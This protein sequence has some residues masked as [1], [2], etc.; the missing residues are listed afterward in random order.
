MNRIGRGLRPSFALLALLAALAGCSSPSRADD[1]TTTTT[2][3]AVPTTTVAPLVVAGTTETGALGFLGSVKRLSVTAL[4]PGKA[5]SPPSA[6]GSPASG[7]LAVLGYRQFGAG[8][9]LLLLPAEGA[10]M[11]WWSPAFLQAL[12]A[13]YR[14]TVLD[15]PGVGYSGPPR[16]LSLAYFADVTAG[17][18]SELGLDKPTVLGWGLGGQVA[19]MLSV[20]HAALL[21]ALV[22]LDTGLAVGASTPPS[23][24]ALALLSDGTATPTQL[25]RVL[26]PPRPAR[27]RRGWVRGLDVEIPDVATSAALQSEERLEDG[28]WAHHL[29]VSDLARIRPPVLVISSAED[30]VF[31]PSDS[32][33]L[34]RAIGKAKHYDF[35]TGGDA[36][37]A[38]E[39][40]QFVD[41]L[42]QFSG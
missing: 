35:P 6:P 21:G 34:V 3:T 17:L 36:V 25:A 24:S 33:A 41:V 32:L 19:A 16:T 27:E 23:R 4:P 2:V 26:F 22:L 30:A 39:P 12:S 10:T 14:V 28:V 8:P 5:S 31:P 1:T 38:A 11:T 29:V 7:R 18:I 13:R 37:F 42:Q 15:L 40:S 9:P 20:R